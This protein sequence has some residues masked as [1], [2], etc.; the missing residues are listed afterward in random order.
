M[1]IEKNGTR[2]DRSREGEGREENSSWKRTQ[3]GGKIEVFSGAR[4]NFW[5]GSFFFHLLTIL[6]GQNRAKPVWDW[7]TCL[8]QQLT[9][10]ST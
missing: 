6:E 9:S 8:A 7:W 4:S 3:R 2:L 1:K 10:P 5:W